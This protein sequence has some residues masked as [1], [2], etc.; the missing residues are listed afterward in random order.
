VAFTAFTGELNDGETTPSVGPFTGGKGAL[1][2]SAPGEGNHG[3]ARLHFPALVDWL[4][5][6]WDGPGRRSATGTATFGVYQGA[7]P[8]IFRREIYRGM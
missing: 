2:L 1:T 5:Y 6:G 3:S 7:T 8:L 4:R